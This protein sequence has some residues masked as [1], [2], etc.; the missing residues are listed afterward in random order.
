MRIT[1]VILSKQPHNFTLLLVFFPLEEGPLLSTPRVKNKEEESFKNLSFSTFRNFLV[2]EYKSRIFKK[3]FCWFDSYKVLLLHRTW[4][5]IDWERNTANKKKIYRRVIEK[6]V[7]CIVCISLTSKSLI[8]R[9]WCI[10]ALFVYQSRILPG[11]IIQQE[12]ITVCIIG[13]LCHECPHARYNLKI[14]FSIYK[15]FKLNKWK[16]KMFS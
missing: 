11:I 8:W 9:K 10:Y 4:N 5:I 16:W 14:L 12:G 13:F 3:L 7:S 2:Q 15:G 1:L 6:T